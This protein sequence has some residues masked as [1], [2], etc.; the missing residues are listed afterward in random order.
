MDRV[1]DMV[2]GI[3]GTLFG[4]VLRDPLTQGTGAPRL[5]DRANRLLLTGSPTFNQQNTAQIAASGILDIEFDLQTKAEQKYLPF[6]SITISNTSASDIKVNAGQHV[7]VV[8]ANST[9]TKTVIAY[10][11]LRITSL[12][13]VNAI[14]ANKLFIATWREPVTEDR[15]TRVK[16]GGDV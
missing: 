5:N 2:N 13:A 15:A 1:N 7:L 3:F 11:R 4:G 12:D 9:R 16:A 6:D 10:R 14:A 8:P